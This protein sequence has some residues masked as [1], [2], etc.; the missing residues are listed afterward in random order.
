LVALGLSGC[1]APLNQHLVYE[2]KGAV[3]GLETDHTTDVLATPPVVNDHPASLPAENVRTVLGSLEV[4]GWSG[5]VVGIFETPR[6]KPVFSQTEL[7]ALAEPFAKAF[8]QASPRERLFFSLQNPAARYETDRTA[9]SMFLRDGYLHLILTDHYGFLKAD[10]GGAEQRDPR[11]MKGM[12][13]WVTRPAQPASVPEDKEPRWGP[14]EKI[15]ISVNV[16]DVLVAFGPNRSS[17]K[18]EAAAAPPATTQTMPPAVRQ[19]AP[20][21]SMPTEH[22]EQQ[23]QDL[24]YANQRLRTQLEQQTSELDKLKDELRKLRDDVKSQKASKP[25]ADR[26]PARKQSSE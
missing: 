3:V 14:L 4:S 18:T 19:T 16:Q 22:L 12:K 10:T 9:G 17:G 23:I 1:A 15:H 2:A 21:A 26:K 5:I 20:A 6:P 13:L 11:D 24:D 25:P 7:T 8:R